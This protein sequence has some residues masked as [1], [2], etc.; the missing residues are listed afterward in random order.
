[1]K[2][3]YK[4]LDIAYWFL[5]K[6]YV[7]KKE[8][9][10]DL[11]IYEGISNMKLQKLLYFA[12]GCF[13]AITDKKLFN[14]DLLAWKHGPVVRTV[15]EEFAYLSGNEIDIDSLRNKEEQMEIFAILDADLAVKP[16]LEE[17]YNT[18]NQYTAWQLRNISHEKGGAWEKVYD[19][20]NNTIIPV[21]SIKKY[22]LETFIED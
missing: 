10:D 22:F 18:F 21:E 11:D 2:R 15:Y 5:F 13:L 9:E 4:A 6:N 7:E 1:M 17:V 19:K 14:E 20:N 3:V 12:Q 8:H 16:I